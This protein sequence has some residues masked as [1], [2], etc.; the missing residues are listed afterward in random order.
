M[1]QPDFRI[2]NRGDGIAVSLPNYDDSPARAGPVPG[3]TTITTM[4]F[5]FERLDVALAPMSATLS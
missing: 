5:D 1:K 4:Y 2:E 3:K